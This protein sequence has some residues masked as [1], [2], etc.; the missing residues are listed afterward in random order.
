MDRILFMDKGQI[1]ED[2]TYEE[3]MA[4]KGHF[5]EYHGLSMRGS[6]Q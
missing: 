1:V 4:L 5:Y 2:G 3:L 6:I